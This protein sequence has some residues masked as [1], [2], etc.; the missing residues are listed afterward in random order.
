MKLMII[1]RD[2]SDHSLQVDE[3]K[4][5]LQSR[6]IIFEEFDVDSLEGQMKCKTYDIVR[7]PS[8]LATKEDGAILQLWQGDLP[9]I[10]AVQG[11]LI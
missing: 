3:F 4:F 6:G 2:K 11:A 1:F 9:T 7:Y 5:N 10:N 8:V